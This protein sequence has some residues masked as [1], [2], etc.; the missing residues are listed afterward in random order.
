MVVPV[1]SVLVPLTVVAPAQI[2]EFTVGVAE[3]DWTVTPVEAALWHLP[4]AVAFAVTTCPAESA[5]TLAFQFPPPFA[6]SVPA[7]IPLTN[8]MIAAPA[9]L[10][11]VTLVA[12]AQI[13]GF[14]VGAAV[15]D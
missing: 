13:V 5:L 3:F 15:F 1:A 14:T 6:V 12:P 7:E 4:V 8:T 9:S 2:G 11:P 10:V